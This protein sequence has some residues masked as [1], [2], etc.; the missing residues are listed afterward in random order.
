MNRVGLSD[1]HVGE[2]HESPDNPREITVED[3]EALCYSLAQDPSMLHARPIIATTEG[4][5]VCGNMRLR[6]ARKLGMETVPTYIKVF[7]SEAQKREWM[8]RDNNQFGSWVPDE[9][10]ALV[11]QHQAEGQDLRLLGFHQ[12]ELRDLLSTS[13]ELPSEDAPIDDIPIIYGVVIDCDGEEEQASLLEELNERGL[14]CRAL[15]A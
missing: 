6:A 7:D 8:L 14:K 2:L 3:F 10:Q 11:R 12:Q 15:M 5:V 9:L 4:E 13:D 1:L